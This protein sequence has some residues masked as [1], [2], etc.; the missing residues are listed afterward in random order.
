MSMDGDDIHLF[1][2]VGYNDSENSSDE[3]DNNDSIEVVSNVDEEENNIVDMT[4]NLVFS[5]DDEIQNGNGDDDHDSSVDNKKNHDFTRSAVHNIR[6]SFNDI[7]GHGFT[8]GGATNN[9]ISSFDDDYSESDLDAPDDD[10]LNVSVPST[11]SYSS[12]ITTNDIVSSDD[13][14]KKQKKRKRRQWSVEEKLE[15][16]TTF[17]LNQ[18]KHRTASQHG[19]TT[20]QLRNWLATESKLISVSKEKKGSLF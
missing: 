4:K 13:K 19:C 10:Q 12:S 3:S 5:S 11:S 20:S 2:L 6:S 9:N 8:L 1:P 18:S 14:I 7:N 15:I 16:L 17:K